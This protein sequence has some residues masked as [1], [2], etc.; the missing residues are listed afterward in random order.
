VE[1]GSLAGSGER[2]ILGAMGRSILKGFGL[3]N[4]VTV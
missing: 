1:L 4:V 2:H 3:A